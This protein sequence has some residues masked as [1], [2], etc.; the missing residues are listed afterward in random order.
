ML[1]KPWRISLASWSQDIALYQH[2]IDS[3]IAF[4]TTVKKILLGIGIISFNGLGRNLVSFVKRLK[5]SLG[6]ITI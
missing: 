2:L 3:L 4:L 6:M 1:P 5:N